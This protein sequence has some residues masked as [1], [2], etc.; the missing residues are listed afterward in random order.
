MFIVWVGEETASHKFEKVYE[1]LKF[2]DR[3]EAG[4]DVERF[5][6]LEA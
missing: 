6:V 1:A 2:A 4:A 3:Y 5:D